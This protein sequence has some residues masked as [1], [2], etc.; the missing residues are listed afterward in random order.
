MN[1]KLRVSLSGKLNKMNRVILTPVMLGA[2]LW[3]LQSV[4]QAALDNR[5]QM[6]GV[7]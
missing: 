6:E 1:S 4:S 7:Q 3:G 5:S 2:I